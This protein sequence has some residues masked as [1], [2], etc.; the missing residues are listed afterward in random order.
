M[1]KMKKIIA[2]LA[3]V[4]MIL[5]CMPAFA[6][7]KP[8]IVATNFVCYDFARQI[9]GDYAS[10]TLLIQPGT[11]VHT[12]EPSP[13][14]ILRIKDADLFVYI[15][16]ESDAWVES[17]LSSFDN[18]PKQV[19]LM[20]AVEHDDDHDDNHDAHGNHDHLAH[21]EHIWTSPDNA[22]D[23]LEY[24]E[25]AICRMDKAHAKQYHANAEAY[26]EEIERIDDAFEDVT[27][28]AKVR[29]IVFA[30]RFPFLHFVNEYHLD[31]MAAYPSCGQDMEPSAQTMMELMECVMKNKID[32]IY[33]IEMSSGNIAQTIAEETGAEI[34][35]M[36]SCQTVT[37][38]DFQA[39]ET[40]VSL[41]RKNVE[42]LKKGLQ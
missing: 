42:A 13:A 22:E 3:S 31:Y 16:G 30:D 27:E 1:N 5:T 10:V 4:I 14:D 11:E 33:I 21:D 24:L 35:T 23:M 32:T 18:P 39:G 8:V 40:Y 15:G 9:V 36:Y 17:I 25:D 37:A 2:W 29:T 12:Y 20:D 6:E 7:E 34:A 38:D 26:E 41:M 28:H 19:K